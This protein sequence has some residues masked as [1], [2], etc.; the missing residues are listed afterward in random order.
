MLK[1]LFS[2]MLLKTTIEPT[3][4]ALN[5][6]NF[7]YYYNSIILAINIYNIYNLINVATKP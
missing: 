6:H 2:Q 7:Y 4:F 5:G 1:I 3:K